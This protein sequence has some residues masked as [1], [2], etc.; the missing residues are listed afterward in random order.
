[1][2]PLFERI[3]NVG[4]DRNSH[5]VVQMRKVRTLATL[6]WLLLVICIPF[7]LRAIEWQIPLRLFTVP[8]AMFAAATTLI[9]L[10]R[11]RSDR[12]LFWSAQW[13]CLGVLFLVEGS[14]L[15]GGGSSSINLGGL[16]VLPLLA[17]VVNGRVPAM[18]W[19]CA[20]LLSTVLVSALE[21]A[22]YEFPS[23]TPEA[24]QHSQYLLQGVGLMLAVLGVLSGFFNQLG[25]SETLLAAQNKELQEQILQTRQAVDEA[26]NAEQAKSLFLANMRHELRTPLNAII[27]FSRRLQK[28]LQGRLD[29]REMESLALILQSGDNMQQLVEDLF[30]LS[31]LDSGQ[32]TLQIG[33]I[34][35]HQLIDAVQRKVAPVLATVNVRLQIE[36][37]ASLLFQGDARRLEQVLVTLVLFSLKL[38]KGGVL[39]LCA[40]CTRDNCLNIEIQDHA[41]PMAPE[42]QARVFDRYNHLHSWQE[43]DTG[44][45]GLSM[46]LARELVLLHEGDLTLSCTEQGNCYCVRLPLSAVSVAMHPYEAHHLQQKT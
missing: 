5:S 28:S 36:V 24:Y 1:M 38:E 10:F 43:L 30:D 44:V 11:F 34:E 6:S 25:Y 15:T 20:G 9:M 45:S 27:G 26:R 31:A 32:L 18:A 14:I 21:F 23:L 12:V 8:F 19:G 40:G 4:W 42:W 17:G 7:L 16:L 3:L 29:S 37:P 35:L 41:A 2:F 39:R 22:G 33:P 46:A 13:L